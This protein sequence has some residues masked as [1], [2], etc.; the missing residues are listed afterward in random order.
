MWIGERENS[1]PKMRVYSKRCGG[2]REIR[3]LLKL[4]IIELG[5]FRGIRGVVDFLVVDFFDAVGTEG[6]HTG[7]AGHGGGGDD[8]G[9][10]ALEEGTE[11]NF[12][13]EHEFLAALAIDPEILWGIKARS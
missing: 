2:H 12:C 1:T 13:V 7:G 8:F 6:L 10:A 5:D 4:D 9:F 11:V 3:D